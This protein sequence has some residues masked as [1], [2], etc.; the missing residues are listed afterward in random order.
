DLFIRYCERV[1]KHVGDL[2]GL[3]TTFNEPN[4]PMLLRWVKSIEL[5]L[6]V[7]IGMAL[8]PAHTVD[9]DWFG[10]FFLGNAERLRDVMI[11]THHRAFIA[12]KSG[13]GEYPV[14]VTI[15]IQDEQPS[16]PESKRDQKRS[17]VY[18]PWL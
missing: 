4:L 10:A 7:I 1:S 14:G 15:S 13:P 8:Q 17:E 6:D 5:P 9:S 18:G 12:L 11:A 16:G 2:I 3:A